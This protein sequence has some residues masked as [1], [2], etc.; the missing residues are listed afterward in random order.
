M[1]AAAWHDSL[2]ISRGRPQSAAMASFP[3]NVVAFDLDGTLADTSPDIA[4]ALNLM[5]GDLGRPP[6]EP[7]H[8]RSLIG[9]G[10]KSLI[11]KALAATGAASDPLVEEGYPIYLGRYGASVC[12]G[13]VRYPHVEQAMDELAARGVRLALC[14]NKPEALT[15]KLLDSLDWSG[16]FEAVVG[17]DSLPWRKPDPR[18]LLETLERAGG[19]RMAFV[20]DSIIDAETAQAAG[21]AFI[22]V[23]FGFSDL[24][25]TEFG[26]GAV[27]DDYAELIAVL[28]RL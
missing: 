12:A 3:F 21:I 26:A 2:A 19:G 24:A 1:C 9:D 25:A 18:P 20:G 28:E 13:T 15:R 16:R 22:A 8:I 4:A 5:L 11:R 27:I 17:G 14:T 6:L 7:E 10:A 23:S